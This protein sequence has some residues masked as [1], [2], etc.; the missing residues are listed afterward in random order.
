[1]QQM[2]DNGNAKSNTYYL[3]N[4]IGNLQ[5]VRMEYHISDKYVK[6]WVSSDK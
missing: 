4:F 2:R 6:K 1:M 5:D 3:A